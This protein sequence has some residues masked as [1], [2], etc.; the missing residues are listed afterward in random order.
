MAESED[1]NDNNLDDSKDDA[2]LQRA[3]EFF[4][5]VKEAESE[6]RKR[7]LD[8]I[9]FARLGDQWPQSV[10]RDRDTSGRPCMTFNKMPSFIRQVVNDS[11]QNKPSISVLPVGAD[12]D[13]DT[14][15][16]L[17]GLIRNIEVQSNADVA[18]DTGIECAVSGGFGYMR[19]KL[20]YTHDDA[21]D[22]DICIDQVGNPLTIYGDPASTKS[23]SSDWNQC[24]VE[25]WI[26]HSEFKKKYPKAE[27]VDWDN[28]YRGSSEWITDT[29][30]MV[31]E[32]W[33]REEEE[34]TIYLLSTGAVVDDDYLEE[35]SED[36]ITAGVQVINER[37]SKRYDVT[38][39]IITAAEVLEKNEWLGQFIPVIPIYGDEV[40]ED[41]KRYFYSLIHQ[42]KDA[43]QSYNYWRTSAVE[44]V[45]LD[46]KA[47]WIGPIGAF[48][49]DPNWLTANTVNHPYLEYDGA[50]PPQRPGPAGV[51]AADIQMALQASDDMKAIIGIYDAAL[52]A[53]SNETSGKA[54]IARQ[55]EAD[56]GT[57]HFIDNMSR[58]I[59]M[60]GKIVIDLIPK[61]YN[62]ERIVRILAEDGTPEQVQINREWLQNGIPRL[63]DLTTGKYDIVVKSGPSFSS[64]REESANQMM[65]LI[66]SNKEL[67]P[68]IGDLIAKNLDWPG[69]DEIADRIKAMLPP[70]I[71]TGIPPQ[72]QQQ[73]D[74][75]NQMVQ[76]GQELVQKLQQDNQSLQLQVKDKQSEFA[77][78][79]GELQ[80]KAQELALKEKELQLQAAKES[81]DMQVQAAELKAKAE[82]RQM[83]KQHAAM[84][85]EIMPVAGQMPDETTPSSPQSP[86][87]P[88]AINVHVDAKTPGSKQI[89]V[90]R[91]SSGKI[92]GATALED[93]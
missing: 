53:R 32:Y 34:C 38:Q 83:M 56:T 49:S 23:D 35:H 6:N 86:A 33:E 59:R 63:Y 41:G 44:K 21:F 16:V 17:E 8:D 65:Q 39:Y 43:Q 78:K 64:R 90:E 31:A 30:V 12:S 70:Q 85:G 20:D 46:T 24:L 88:I 22:L 91:D 92:I 4:E 74:H 72:V 15:Q 7:Y 54:I 55:R 48:N 77:I 5:R 76:Q 26:D 19:V 13:K 47:P 27:M 51:P 87:Q 9:R 18:Y 57:F 45:A 11:R 37:P 52:G 79:Q 93:Y 62:K 58:A 73:L 42:A 82:D 28:D 3:R 10:K 60:L 25:D 68:I 40:N 2:V 75:V 29:Q 66:Q 1:D 50:I 14:A 84:T 80:L 67:A 69:S 89:K 81:V 71:N 36:L 61:V